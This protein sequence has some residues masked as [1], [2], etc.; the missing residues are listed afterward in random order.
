MLLKQPVTSRVLLIRPGATEFDDQGRIKGSLDMPMSQRGR[1]QAEQ[2]VGELAGAPIRTIYTSPC[3]SA[4]ETAEL[5]ARGRDVKIKVLDSFRNVDHGLWHGKLI[6]EVKRNQPRAYR[7]GQ[8]S[9]D[10]FCAPRG[11]PIAEAKSRV[12]KSLKK[13]VRKGRRRGDR[14]GHHR[15]VGDC[16][17]ELAQRRGADRSLEVRDGRGVV[18]ADRVDPLRPACGPGRVRVG[19]QL[20]KAARSWVGARGEGRRLTGRGRC[21]VGCS[22]GGSGCFRMRGCG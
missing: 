4:R 11:E 21:R 9:P 10:A 2:L 14:V 18:A 3:Q 12:I 1:R 13:I 22:V 19:A 5:L 7:L 6:E 16:R 20:R 15:A 17:S 8:D